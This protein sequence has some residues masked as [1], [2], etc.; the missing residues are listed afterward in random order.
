MSWIVVVDSDAVSQQQLAV[1]RANPSE[2][3]RG[4]IECDSDVNRDTPVCHQVTHFPA[5]CHEPSNSC[6]YGLRQTQNDLQELN[7][8]APSQST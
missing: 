1:C 5:F 7:A 2:H 3:V 4:A 6:V 8:I